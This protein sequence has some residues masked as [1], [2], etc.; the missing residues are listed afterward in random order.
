MRFVIVIPSSLI[1]L[2]AVFIIGSTRKTPRAH[3]VYPAPSTAEEFLKRGELYEKEGNYEK[4]LSDYVQAEKLDP[5]DSSVY[6]N[7]GSVLS[8]LEQ[9][10][11][12]IEKYLIVKEIDQR[13]NLPTHM[14]DYLID[15][16]KEKR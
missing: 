13:N 8:A 3:V 10:D 2:A 16:E 4:A 11:A 14:I 12:A 6:L 5:N 1:L 7:Q 9:P 15:K